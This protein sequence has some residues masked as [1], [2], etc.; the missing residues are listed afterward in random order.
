[1]SIH[2][3]KS[4]VNTIFVRPITH[5]F[6]YSW[7]FFNKFLHY[8]MGVDLNPFLSNDFPSLSYPF[9]HGF[10]IRHFVHTTPYIFL[11]S[12]RQLIKCYPSFPKGQPLNYY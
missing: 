9:S 10:F 8:Y 3:T 5:F 2:N 11:M 1:L 7:R 4:Q 12:G 6:M